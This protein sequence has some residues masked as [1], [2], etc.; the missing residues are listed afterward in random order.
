MLL[1]RTA[2]R[3]GHDEDDIQ[4]IPWLGNLDHRVLRTIISALSILTTKAT[5][6]NG[7][8]HPLRLLMLHLLATLFWEIMLWLSSTKIE[9]TFD[10]KDYTLYELARKANLLSRTGLQLCFRFG[11]GI[12]ALIC[13]YVAICRFRSL[14]A[15]SMLLLPDWS[16]L[17]Y[18]V[19]HRDVTVSRTIL[20][21]LG[22]AVGLVLILGFETQL[23]EVGVKSASTGLFLGLAAQLLRQEPSFLDDT[24]C[25]SS[26]LPVGP[27]RDKAILLPLAIFIT[28]VGIYKRE[29]WI[30]TPPLSKVSLAVLAINVLAAG[31]AFQYSGSHFRRSEAVA[32]FNGIE[33]DLDDGEVEPILETLALYTVIA[34]GSFL[35]SPS[36]P[37]SVV[38]IEQYVGFLMVLIALFWIGRQ[39]RPAAV[40]DTYYTPI[41]ALPHSN[42]EH[43]LPEF[44]TLDLNQR[45]RGIKWGDL[46]QATFIGL[47]ILLSA[48]T[49]KTPSNSTS[50]N[51]YTQTLPSTST[52]AKT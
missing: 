6:A 49:T 17:V 22:C 11:C 21:C 15:L 16:Q 38:S 1:L 14:P 5:F 20:A 34:L 2:Y 42:T 19:R 46:L 41:D 31:L 7:I 35:I 4:Q 33:E 18:L 23:S 10:A 40:D 32:T 9:R 8:H 37:A 29:Y 48:P 47:C 45:H 51:I 36:D 25:T 26:F 43:R 27:V 52:L 30:Y 28:A 44:E 24:R 13:E 39:C 50:K 12:G 3:L